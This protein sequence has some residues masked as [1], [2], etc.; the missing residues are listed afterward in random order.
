M[1]FLRAAAFGFAAAVAGAVV[2]GAILY[3]THYQIGYVALLVGYIV[4]KSVRKGSGGR[5]GVGYQ[6]MAI[7][8]TYCVAAAAHFPLAFEAFSSRGH[9]PVAVIVLKSVILCAM[10]PIV[11]GMKNP[12]GFLILG[13]ALWEAWKFTKYQ[14]IPL[15]GP[16]QLAT[17]AQP[18][19]LAPLPD[20]A[21]PPGVII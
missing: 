11:N 8:L 16:H 7:L 14:P 17:R 21:P 3:Y 5:G 12:I 13:I 6:I 9:Q 1:R 19:S 10:D 2:W 18:I 4:G 15:S 20:P